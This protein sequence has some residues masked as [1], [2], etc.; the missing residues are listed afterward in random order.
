MTEAE[1]VQVCLDWNRH[2][3]PPLPDE[4]VRATVAS[5]AKSE[6]RK[7][8][9][10]TSP[11]NNKSQDKRDVAQTSSNAATVANGWRENTFTAAKLQR[12]TF[13]PP[14]F[15]LPQYVP[16][17]VTLLIGRP[18]IGKSWLALDLAVACSSDLS[19][20]GSLKPA[21]GDVLYLALEDSKRRLQSR[22]DRLASPFTT[23]WP[24]RLS[25]VEAGGW[26]RADQGGLL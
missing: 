1:A 14:R 13:E 17:G 21:Q 19:V 11:I 10:D 15:V 22:I 26:R 20:L 9:A 5:I 18:K 8:E 24:D 16:E 12:M 2:N 6:M 23:A 4:K 25:I 3:T 7:R